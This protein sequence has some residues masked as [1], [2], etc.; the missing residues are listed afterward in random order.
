MPIARYRD[1]SF[2]GFDKQSPVESERV[3]GRYSN[4]LA[5]NFSDENAQ[6]KARRDLQLKGIWPDNGAMKIPKGM[7]KT[8]YH[9]ISPDG[10]P[11]TPEPFG[12][13]QL[14][15]E[16][17][18]KYCVRMREQGYYA[19]VGERIPLDELP[20]RLV[21]VPEA[22]MFEAMQRIY[23]RDPI[24]EKVKSWQHQRGMEWGL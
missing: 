4:L 18:P 21:I 22:D 19:A 16:F 6:N 5:E 9:I 24:E 11:L 10:L 14:A 15:E 7:D 1:G 13:K 23:D 2:A 3:Q 12:S 20:G 8:P 17:V